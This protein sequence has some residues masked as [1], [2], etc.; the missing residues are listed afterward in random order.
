MSEGFTDIFNLSI[1]QARVP[2]CF[3]KTT[4]IP[5]PKKAHAVCLNDEHPVALTSIIMQCFK[6]L[7]IAHIN[8]SLP[9][10]L[11]P[12]Q[13][14]YQ[15]NRSTDDAISLALHSP[16][17][18]LDNKDTYVRLLLIDY[19]SSFNTI[20]PSRMISKLRDL[21]LGSTFCNWIPSF[22][23]H[24]LQSVR[25]EQII[26]FRKKGG[27]HTPIYINGIEVER[28]KSIKFLR[29]TIT[30]NLSWTSHVDVIVKKAQ[31]RLFFLRCNK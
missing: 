18:Y 28:V 3:K 30:D 24:R 13:F 25:I 17:E 15:S 14:A 19:S 26:N 20:I 10:C 16:L 12:L 27:E 31:R 11:N 9:A 29:V 1:L 21:G 22:L 23:T 5:I 8:S 4:I 2:T 6:R 7:V